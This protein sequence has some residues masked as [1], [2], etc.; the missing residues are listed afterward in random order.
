MATL[1]LSPLCS[2][3][4]ERRDIYTTSLMV[5]EGE[6]VRGEGERG[7]GGRKRGSR[8]CMHAHARLH[9]LAK[10][11]TLGNSRSISLSNFSPKSEVFYKLYGQ[12]FG[13]EF[14]V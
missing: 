6:K 5:W 9:A 4:H 10:A 14:R 11:K 2:L 7:E 3:A 12:Y 1:S 8:V 13:I